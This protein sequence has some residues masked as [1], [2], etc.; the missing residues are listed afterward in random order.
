M[1]KHSCLGWQITCLLGIL[2]AAAVGQMPTYSLEAAAVNSAPIPGGPVSCIAL[3]A[4]D[5]F[6][7]EAYL[8]DWSPNGDHVAAYQVQLDPAGFSSGPAGHIEPI[9]YR[10][11][12]QAG[13][14]NNA[15]CFIDKEHPRYLHAGLQNLPLTDT[16]SEGYR[17]MSVLLGAEGPISSQDGTKFYCGSVK[18]LVSDDAQGKFT[19][20]LL[21]N[22]ISSGLRDNTNRPI[23]PINFEPLTIVVRPSLG[24]LIDGLNGAKSLPE[25]QADLDHDGQSGPADVL[26]VIS[27]LNRAP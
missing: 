16:R 14:E 19:M 10:N 18:F 23:E 13:E 9:D 24:S 1:L 26:E 20:A 25:H 7:M 15:N 2:P 22:A 8:R 27:M 5:T 17:L 6:T 4:G 11:T 12:Q 21:E 3:S